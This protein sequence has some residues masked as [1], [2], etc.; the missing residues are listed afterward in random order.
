MPSD[1]EWEVHRSLIR[2]LAGQKAARTRI[3]RAR[4]ID[5]PNPLDTAVMIHG[6]KYITYRNTR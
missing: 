6:R 5:Y 2:K 4:K 3:R 1:L